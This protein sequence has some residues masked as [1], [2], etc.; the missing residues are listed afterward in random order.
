MVADYEKT[1]QPGQDKIVDWDSLLV[2]LDKAEDRLVD[3][4]FHYAKRH[5]YTRYTSTLREAWRM[6]AAGLT[7]SLM[8]A[9]TSCQSIP[10]LSPDETYADDPAAAFGKLEAQRHRERGISLTMFLGL[11]KYF[12]QAYHDVLRDSPLGTAPDADRYHLFLERA[13]DRFEL[14]FLAEWTSQTQDDLLHELQHTNRRITNE[15]NKYLTIFES[16]SSPVLFV[17]ADGRLENLNHS[18][19]TLLLGE[20]NPGSIYY[21]EGGLQAHFAWLLPWL[22]RFER[23]EAPQLS[24]EIAM[25]TTQ[26]RRKF[27]G[28]LQRMLDRSTKFQGTIVILADVTERERA[29]T[30]LQAAHD[31]LE[32]RVRERTAELQHSAERLQAE[33]VER[34]RAE[35]ERESTREQLLHAQKLEAVGTLAGGVAHDLN[36][37]LQMIMGNAELLGMELDNLSDPELRGMNAQVLQA[38]ERSAAL[39]R[40]LLLFSRRQ[41]MNFQPVCLNEASRGMTRMLDRLIG[42][43]IRV[44]TDLAERLHP[45]YGDPGSLEQV[46]MNLVLNARDAMPE[47]GTISLRTSAATFGPEDRSYPGLEPGDYVCLLVEDDGMGMDADT[48]DRIFEP[49]FTTKRAGEGTGLGLSVVYGIVQKHKGWIKVYSEPG[50]GSTF[51]IYLPAMPGADTLAADAATPIDALRGQGQEILLIEDEGGV[52]AYT[53]T[54]L[55]SAGYCVQSS[56]NAEVAARICIDRSEPFD[57][58]ISDVMLPGM[59]GPELLRRLRMEHPRQRALFVSGY[60]AGETGTVEEQG[61]RLLSKPFALRDLLQ[62]VHDLLED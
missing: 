40:Q 39:V 38:T 35:R 32:D 25:A 15:K 36:N 4:F 31:Q 33:M 41:P 52:R 62:A 16:I 24:F 29:R 6:S 42:E 3:R 49:F 7:D 57:L 43:R 13:F 60:T 54:A 22:R 45:V 2:M 21:R 53:H 55:E 10:E 18:A 26:G 20:S 37:L 1:Q 46:L 8:D 61:D 14:G 51:R 59:T 58:I 23:S 28:R 9:L 12:R 19:A 56:G 17:S 48:R 50:V 44:R 5:D 47:G 27:E 30:Q 34:Q 11:F